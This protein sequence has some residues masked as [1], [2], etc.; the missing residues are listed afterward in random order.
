MLYKNKQIH[1][2]EKEPFKEDKLNREEYAK[3]LLQFF[4]NTEE[5]LTLSINSGWGTGK[6]IFVL[7]LKQLLENEGFPT[8]LFN[9]WENDYSDDAFVSLIGEIVNEIKIYKSK[10]HI[11]DEEIT[12]FVKDGAKLVKSIPHIIKLLSAN[13]IDLKNL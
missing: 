3:I 7:M 2:F 6:T 13:P 5:P 9:A 8:I 1:I 10:Y 12:Q 11:M 4:S